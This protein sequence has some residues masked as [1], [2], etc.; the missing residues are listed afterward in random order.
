LVRFGLQALVIF[1]SLAGVS[2]GMV[3]RHFVRADLMVR[4]TSR[5][6]WDAAI[7]NQRC[8]VFID[9]DWNGDVVAFRKPFATFSEWCQSHSDVRVLTMAIDADDASN[10]VWQICEELW[11]KNDIHAGGLKN[12]GGAGRVLWI[13]QG[14]LVDHAW[15]TEVIHDTD[16]GNIDPLKLRT[17]RAFR[18]VRAIQP[19]TS[20]R[21]NARGG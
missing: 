8:I 20:G 17:E 10:D 3:G 15:C 19:R 9:A 5:S 12:Y 6:Q 2:A 18:G 7:N 21:K 4:I 13:A 1:V 14:R 11:R 16:I